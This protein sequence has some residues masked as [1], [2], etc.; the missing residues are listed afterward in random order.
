MQEY[1]GEAGTL[2][3]TTPEPMAD[4]GTTRTE[5]FFGLLRRFDDSSRV[6]TCCGDFFFLEINLVMGWDG[7][8]LAQMVKEFC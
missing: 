6:N 3:F 8:G 5:V 1:Y 4:A 7:S 2:T